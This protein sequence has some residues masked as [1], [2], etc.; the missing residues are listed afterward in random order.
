MRSV[1]LET[2]I[3]AILGLS[4]LALADNHN[5]ISTG[6]SGIRYSNYYLLLST[7]TEDD[8]PKQRVREYYC[9]VV[10]SCFVP[11]ST[12]CRPRR[13]RGLLGTWLDWF[14]SF[15]AKTYRN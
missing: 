13:H 14:N 2:S 12:A 11:S 1:I 6:F 5:G 3:P 8:Q 10:G 4:L 15:K 9:L 7:T